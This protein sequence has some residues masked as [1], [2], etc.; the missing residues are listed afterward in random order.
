DARGRRSRQRA[1]DLLLGRTVAVVAPAGHAHAARQAGHRAFDADSAAH[2]DF[3]L[4]ALV[5]M[6]IREPVSGGDCRTRAR[7]AL[8]RGLLDAGRSL[9]RSPQVIDF[10]LMEGY[11]EFVWLSYG[12]TLAIVIG[13]GWAS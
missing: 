8:A 6:G 4:L 3:R 13:L 10:L 1:A 11:A 7:F 5:R 2:V 12:I 9:R